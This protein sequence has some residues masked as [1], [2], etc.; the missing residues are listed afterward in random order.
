MSYTTARLRSI[1]IALLVSTGTMSFLLCMEGKQLARGQKKARTTQQSITSSFTPKEILSLQKL[2]LH[3]IL[4]NVDTIEDLKE[5]FNGGLNIFFDSHLSSINS[6]IEQATKMKKRDYHLFLKIMVA[7]HLLAKSLEEN[8]KTLEEQE[9]IKLINQ[10]STAYQQA[11]TT[12]SSISDAMSC[13]IKAKELI[14]QL[15]QA[16]EYTDMVLLRPLACAA[17]HNC[18]LAVGYILTNYINNN[19]EIFRSMQQLIKVDREKALKLLN[20]ANMHCGRDVKEIEGPAK[21]KLF[22]SLMEDSVY[23][24][25][26]NDELSQ[27]LY[28]HYSSQKYLRF[29][30]NKKKLKRALIEG[31]LDYFKELLSNNTLLEHFKT[32]GAKKMGDILRNPLEFCIKA[33][34]LS[35]FELLFKLN[36]PEA[37][38]K[39]NLSNLLYKACE[40]GIIPLIKLVLTKTSSTDIA[41]SKALDIAC[42]KGNVEVVKLLLAPGTPLNP[43][44][45]NIIFPLHYACQGYQGKTKQQ[46][47]E[48]VQLLLA[49]K[50]PVGVHDNEGQTP[51][52]YACKAGN[53]QVVK[54]LLEHSA[55]LDVQDKHGKTAFINACEAHTN[56]YQSN[57]EANTREIEELIQ[58]LLEKKP[59]LTFRYSPTLPYEISQNLKGFLT[60]IQLFSHPAIKELHKS[61]L[62]LYS[63]DNF[64][65]SFL[66][67]I[68]L[69]GHASLMGDRWL[70][71]TLSRAGSKLDKSGIALSLVAVCHLGSLPVNSGLVKPVFVGKS[72]VLH[73][74]CLLGN[75]KLAEELLK[76]GAAVNAQDEQGNTPLHL[77]CTKAYPTEESYSIENCKALID[78]L[79]SYGANPNIQNKDEY[80]PFTLA[81]SNNGRNDLGVYLLKYALDSVE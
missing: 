63:V 61:V 77:V 29:L 66:K 44:T 58:Y 68:S 69:L 54:L 80:I 47:Y 26:E 43:P 22:N 19:A 48:I 25:L 30:E 13:S 27:Q 4:E 8:E 39:K 3:T 46:T 36:L 65:N 12:N 52:H 57:N 59:C 21:T 60:K 49:H 6:F 62:Q 40:S 37:K 31:D 23:K 67:N 73:A 79:L 42:S 33:R 35:L 81:T 75:K 64:Y 7:E 15:V 70:I 28:P 5:V 76:A 32:T 71:T 78:L 17:L 9:I 16:H 18:W 50:A 11:V 1:L 72:T 74:A 41:N 2:C 24:Q 56:C 45:D 20:K 34:Y 14:E 38:N 53:L 10:K 51:L 55:P